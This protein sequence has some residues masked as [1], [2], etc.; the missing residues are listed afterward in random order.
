MGFKE[1]NRKDTK[2]QKGEGVRENAAQG[3]EGALLANALNCSERE[4]LCGS[5]VYFPLQI[6]LRRDDQ[7]IDGDGAL[8]FG[9]NDEWVDIDALDGFPVCYSIGRQPH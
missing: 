7:G 1:I 8:T 2:E 9:Q 3:R 5:V 4:I 6:S